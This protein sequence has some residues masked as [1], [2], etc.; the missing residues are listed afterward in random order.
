MS[1]LAE[2]FGISLNRKS[3]RYLGYLRMSQVNS[4]INGYT[5]LKQKEADAVKSGS[6]GQGR[7][8]V[9]TIAGLK[10]VPGVVVKNKLKKLN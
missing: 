9:N 3:E 2:T 7:Q 6:G 10:H 1:F 4:L 5:K 8:E